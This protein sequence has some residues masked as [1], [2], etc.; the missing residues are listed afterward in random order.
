MRQSIHKNF[1]W[2][3]LSQIATWSG[4]LVLVVVAPRH[5]SAAEFG[6]FQFA[7][8]FVGYFTLVG[9]LGTSTYLVKAIAR[10]DSSVGPYVLNALVMKLALCTVLS[11]VAVMLAHLLAYPNETIV[12]VEVACFAMIINVLNDTLAAALQGLERMNDFALWKVA[13][14][15]VGVGIGLAVLLGDHGI[16]AYAIVVPLGSLVPLTAN[17]IH[18]WPHLRKSLK[19]D[20]SVWTRLVKGGSPFLLWSAILVIYGTIDIPLLRAMAGEAAVGAY[21]LAYL[22]VGMPAGF[23]NVVVTATM[24]SM[25]ANAIRES[26]GEFIRLANRSIC[27]VLLFGLP[28]SIGIALVAGDV[29]ALLHYQAGF[30]SAVVLI[31]I[32]ALHIPVVGMDMVLGSALIAADRQKQWTVIGCSAAV[33]NPLLNLLAIPLTIHLFN[34]GAIGAA[35]ITVATELL[36]MVGALIIRPAGIMDRSTVSYALRCAVA[37]VVM[38][39]VVLAF[40]PAA[41]PI[42]IAAGVLAFGVASL[43]LGTVSLDGFRLGADGRYTLGRFLKTAAIPSE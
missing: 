12:L 18:V 29:F 15:V 37:S 6:A 34:N 25:S 20:F 32:L 9:T 7:A 36:M 22:W 41:L 26:K 38:V 24:P 10:D 21:A 4:S 2:L 8:I 31:Q 43:A 40:G 17:L 39:P 13:Q 33:L 1:I 30:E 19:L 11:A 3:A 14:T 28:A 35:V 27:L 5:L 42:K 16:V 23:S